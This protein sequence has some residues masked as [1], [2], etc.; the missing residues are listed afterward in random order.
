MIILFGSL[1]L[2][3]ALFSPLQLVYSLNFEVEF[4]LRDE[5]HGI[6]YSITL[7]AVLDIWLLQRAGDDEQWNLQES[8][9]S[10]LGMCT[11]YTKCSS[12]SFNEFL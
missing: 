3:L 2:F 9:Y 7:V 1:F 11:Q 10:L 4:A 12:S 8:N 5:E 6:E